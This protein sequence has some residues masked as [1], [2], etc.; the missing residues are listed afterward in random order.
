LSINGKRKDITRQDLI[1]L[2]K[3]MNIKKSAQIIDHVVST[4]ANWGS[5][6]EKVAIE[7]GLMRAIKKTLL[8]L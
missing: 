6:A 1:E 4:I 3:K 7:D 8:E 2:A 5:Y